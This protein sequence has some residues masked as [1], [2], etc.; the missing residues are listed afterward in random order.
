[1]TLSATKY[2]FAAVGLGLLLSAAAVYRH[3]ASFVSRAH[4]A[5]GAV[6]ALLPQR[7]TDHATTYK[8]VVRFELD[9]RQIQFSDSVSSNPPA[10]SVGET[11]N[12]LYLESSPYEARIDSF[13]SLWFLPSLLGGM[14]TIFLTIGGGLILVPALIRRADQRLLH[15][16]RPIEAEFQGVNVNSAISVNGRCPYRVTAQW[17]DPA[18]SRVRVFQSHDLW[19]DPTA[20]IKEKALKVY[21][22]PNN[23]SRY[24]V[25]LSFLPKL[26]G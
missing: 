23:P 15:E 4:R 5:L 18:T 24:Y 6:T 2:L 12:V 16:G 10:Y 7:S 21:L 26:A 14:G 22:D 19:F 8:P 1:M 9:G 11:V 3:T 25:D 20:Y 13:A 17:V